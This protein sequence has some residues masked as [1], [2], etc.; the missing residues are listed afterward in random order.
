V[1]SLSLPLLRVLF[2]APTKIL[3]LI[4]IVQEKYNKERRGNSSRKI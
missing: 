4:V 3:L 1:S 2:N